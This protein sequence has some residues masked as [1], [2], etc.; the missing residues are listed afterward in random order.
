MNVTLR[1]PK[2]TRD[3]F[4]DWVE[5]QEVPY[6]FDGF[7]PI[8]MNG[9]SVNH[10]RICQNLWYALRS[11]LLGTRCEVLGPNLGVNTIGN[12]VRYPDALVHCE[13]LSGLERLA[14][15]VVVLFEVVSPTSVRND[16]VT[17]LREY[18]VMPT[19]RR[20]VV[21]EDSAAEVTAFARAAADDAWTAAVLVAG[22]TLV[23]PE[24]DIEISVDELYEGV[25]LQP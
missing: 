8:A 15:G 4:L 18:G 9:S 25:T 23:L 21:L 1:T 24:I 22:Q 11:R 6:E 2:M 3:E 5:R 20:Y 19:V 13:P 10:G 17:K 12:A 7:E 16:H 14:A